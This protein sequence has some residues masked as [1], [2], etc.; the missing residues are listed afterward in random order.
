MSISVS[1]QEGNGHTVTVS[2][3]S[4]NAEVVTSHAMTPTQ[5]PAIAPLMQPHLF[6]FFQVMHIAIGTTADPST[7]PMNSCDTTLAVYK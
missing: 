1:R 7:T 6:A 4:F 2:E 5:N 3:P